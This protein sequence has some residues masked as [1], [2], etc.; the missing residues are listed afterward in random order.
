MHCSVSCI[1]KIKCGAFQAGAAGFVKEIL[2]L[3]DDTRGNSFGSGDLRADYQGLKFAKS[4][5][6]DS[7]CINLCESRYPQK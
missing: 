5:N 2:D 7:E 1:L 6:T 3:F 4:S